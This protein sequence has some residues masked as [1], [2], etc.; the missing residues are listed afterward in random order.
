M[1]VNHFTEKSYSKINYRSRPNIWLTSIPLLFFFWFFIN[2]FYSDAR[3]STQKA[4]CRKVEFLER[5]NVQKAELKNL[6]S[7]ESPSVAK[8]WL[9]NTAT[10]DCL[11]ERNWNLDICSSFIKPVQPSKMF[12]SVAGQLTRNMFRSTWTLSWPETWNLNTWSDLNWPEL[13]IQCLTLQN[14]F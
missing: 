3:G 6:N 1:V 13:C 9:S 10:C 14:L 7:P 2:R 4:T 8:N 12:R 11:V 5:L